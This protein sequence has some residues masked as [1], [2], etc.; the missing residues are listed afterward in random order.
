MLHR[1]LSDL[2]AKLDLLFLLFGNDEYKALLA[3]PP[4]KINLSGSGLAL[5]SNQVYEAGEAMVVKM[6]LPISPL[7]FIELIVE[8][9][10]CSET[11]HQKE[12]ENKYRIAT[13]YLSISDESREKIIKYVFQRQ[14]EILREKNEKFDDS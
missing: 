4:K 14:R 5:Y 7:A 9:V 3:S 10:S 8:V 12:E 13:K 1:V 11:K 2:N 6:A